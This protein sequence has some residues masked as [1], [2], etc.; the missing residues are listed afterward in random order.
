MKHDSSW[1]LRRVLESL[2]RYLTLLIVSLELAAASRREG[3]EKKKSVLEQLKAKAQEPP[4][5][6]TAPKRSAERE[7]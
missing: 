5:A 4:A 3:Q 2:G 6:K 1:A 7:L